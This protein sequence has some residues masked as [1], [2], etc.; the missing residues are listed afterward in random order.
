ME[1]CEYMQGGGAQ[2]EKPERQPH[3]QTGAEGE[4][5]QAGTGDIP[6]GVVR[7]SLTSPRRVRSTRADDAGGKSGGV[8]KVTGGACGTRTCATAAAVAPCCTGGASGHRGRTS[9]RVGSARGTGEAGEEATGRRTQT[10]G[11]GSHIPH[12]VKLKNMVKLGLKQSTSKIHNITSRD[13]ERAS[14]GQKEAGNRN[15]QRE[16]ETDTYTRGD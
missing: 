1:V 5:T 6:V 8:R 16:R 11:E 12:N 10:D 13:R 9:R 14:G 15:R 2:C 3:R 7:P 4:R